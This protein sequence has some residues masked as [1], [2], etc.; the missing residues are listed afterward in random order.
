MDVANPRESILGDLLCEDSMAN[1]ILITGGARSGKSRTAPAVGERLGGRRLFVATCPI[2]DDEEMIRRIERHKEERAQREWDAVEEPSEIAAALRRSSA[3]DVRVVDCMTMWV[4]NLMY[5]GERRGLHVDEDFISTRCAELREACMALNG[6]V[7]FVTNE[8]G[9]AIVPENSLARRFRDLV[10]HCNRLVA[11]NAEEV[12]LTVCG[13][14]LF[15][16]NG[17]R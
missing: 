9:W 13:L 16:K 3:Y 4:N 17:D 5:E 1:V 6:T 8:V 10:G 12:I 2:M 11:E 15:V 14:P 7:I